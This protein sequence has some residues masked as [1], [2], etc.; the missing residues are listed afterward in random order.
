MKSEVVFDQSSDRCGIRLAAKRI[1][2]ACEPKINAYYR[3]ADSSEPDHASVTIHKNRDCR[4]QEHDL[5]E[6]SRK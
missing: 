1:Q 6:G 5:Q 3:G 4:G 2:G